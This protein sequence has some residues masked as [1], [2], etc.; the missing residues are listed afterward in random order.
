MS[1]A[2]LVGSLVGVTWW[3]MVLVMFVALLIGRWRRL[4]DHGI[5]VPSMVLLSLITVNGTDSDFTYLTIVETVLGGIVGVAV[6]AVVLAPMHLDEPRDALRDLTSRV[7]AVLG[8]IADGLRE[9]WTPTGPAAGTTTRPTWA[10]GSPRRCGPW[11]PA[12]RAPAGTGG[13]ACARP[14][15]TGTA[16]CAPSKRC[17]APSGRWPASHAPSSTPPTTR[18]GTRRRPRPGCAPTPTSSTR[19]GR[20]S[21]TSAC[22]PT[23]RVPR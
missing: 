6:N 10:T 4:G 17:A 23:T 18:T 8:D 11:R 22:G 2:W 20:R 7:Q 12:A 16:T 3:S 9:G 19:W 13:T 1:I 14:G 15:S 21:R 5:Q